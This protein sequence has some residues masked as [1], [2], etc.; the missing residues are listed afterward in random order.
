[1]E[2]IY[3]LFC[4]Y[5]NVLDDPEL[6]DYK[7][8][9]NLFEQYSSLPSLDHLIFQLSI[10]FVC[11]H[12]LGHLVQFSNK[13]LLNQTAVNAMQ[14]AYMTSI[15]AFDIED[16]VME[17]DADMRGARFLVDGVIDKWSKLPNDI[18]TEE[19]LKKLIILSLVGAS[20]FFIMVKKFPVTGIYYYET[21][22]PHPLIRLMWLSHIVVERMETHYPS[23]ER[24][25]IIRET[26]R[27]LN[28]YSKYKHLGDTYENYIDP[29][30]KHAKDISDYLYS[31]VET[32]RT[33]GYEYLSK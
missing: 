23:L 19:N 32:A 30:V 7:N 29:Y 22:H 31:L 21:T 2:E 15:K 17:I 8:L 20:S 28:V 4:N 14:E 9:R 26:L 5:H 6:V 11:F 18:K 3:D 16:H 1:M 24:D 13:E 25:D 27:V 10:F 12:E 33:P